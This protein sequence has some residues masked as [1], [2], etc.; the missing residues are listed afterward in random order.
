MPIL[1]FRQFTQIFKY[2]IIIFFKNHLIFMCLLVPAEAITS[3]E[4]GVTGE[5]S[6][7]VGWN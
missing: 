1:P 3:P 2:I 6:D 4:A 7:L 5:P